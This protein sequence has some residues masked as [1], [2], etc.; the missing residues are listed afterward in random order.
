MKVLTTKGRVSRDLLEVTDIVFEE[1]NARVIATEWR[2]NG[3]IVRR[4]VYV[5]PFDWPAVNTEQ[6]APSA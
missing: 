1:E 4:D 2:L 5:N 6:E 3:E